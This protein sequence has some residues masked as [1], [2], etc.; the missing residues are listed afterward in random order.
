MNVIMI[1]IISMT[2]SNVAVC[3]LKNVPLH[4]D[5]ILLD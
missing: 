2:I 1:I 4:N 3:K 5:K